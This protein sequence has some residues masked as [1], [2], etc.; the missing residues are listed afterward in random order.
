MGI[1]S[2]ILVALFVLSYCFSSVAQIDEQVY[3]I[4]GKKYY[5]HTVEAGNTL[6]G[7]S[8]KYS[9]EIEDIISANKGVENG[10]AI[11]E[12]IQIPVEMVRKQAIRVVPPRVENDYIYHTV[13]RGETMYFLSKRYKVPIKELRKLNPETKSGLRAGQVL[14]IEIAKVKPEIAVA[15]IVANKGN[16]MVHEVKP[17][18]T[19]YSIS[20]KY[21]VAIDSLKL[22]NAG[23]KN[24]LKIGQVLRIPKKKE[25]KEIAMDR[26]RTAMQGQ[27]VVDSVVIKEKYN[28]CLM[29][30]LFLDENDTLEVNAK[31]HDPPEIYP[32]SVFSLEF[33]HGVELAL[34]ELRQKGLSINFHVYDTKADEMV[35]RQLLSDP[36]MKDMNLFI[37]PFN[38]RNVDL[39]ADFAI[40]QGVHVVC[41]VDQ[42]NKVLLSNP[43]VSKVESSNTTQVEKLAAFVAERHH[44]DNVIMIDSQ[45]MRDDPLERTFQEHY[46]R[47]VRRYPSRRSDAAQTSIIENYTVNELM[48]KMDK[49]SINVLVMPSANKSAVSDFMTRVHGLQKK[50]YIIDVF[51]IQKWLSFDNIEV[52]YKH[53]VNLHVT[54]GHHINYESEAM[55][56]FLQA[57]RTEFFTDPGRYAMMGY[58]IGSYYLGGLH[59]FGI[60][61]P[62]YFDAIQHRPVHLGF[63]H[64]VTGVESGFE[65]RNVYILRYED[66]NVVM[67]D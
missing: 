23:L 36:K 59:Q 9:V 50:G 42:S 44:K 67:A 19:L 10:L 15:K 12:K 32:M 54:S 14:K 21:G 39:V 16:F 43:N 41:A 25:V 66:Y 55:R 40:R 37:G 28:V 52:D 65:N 38:H 63:D 1:K 49:N 29:L 46:R 3:T 20:R 18:E 4:K 53:D 6:Y 2:Y 27:V 24:E 17:K 45:E 33:M 5:L 35:V 62:K 48:E 22:A 47:A 7:I 56:D 26:P 61:F 57:Y 8:K 58:D 51:G 64:Q 34:E 11:G 13:A 30:P 31:P 60:D